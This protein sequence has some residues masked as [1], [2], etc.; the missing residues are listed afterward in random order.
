MASQYEKSNFILAK[1]NTAKTSLPTLGSSNSVPDQE[2]TDLVSDDFS[3][4]FL[5][6]HPG[7]VEFGIEDINAK[8]ICIAGHNLA[9]NGDV[10]VEVHDSS[11][12]YVQKTVTDGKPIF[13]D[14]TLAPT[15]FILLRITG[16][17][18]PATV[19]LSQLMYGDVFNPRQVMQ[20][21]YKSPYLNSHLYQAAVSSTQIMPSRS[22]TKRKPIPV[23]MSFMNVIGFNVNDWID[24]TKFAKRNNFVVVEKHYR[25]DFG[26]D[27]DKTAH[28]GFQAQV[29]H[30]HSG[31]SRTLNDIKLKY[32]AYNGS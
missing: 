26:V 27:L 3:E 8:Y 12:V 23:S 4:K 31:K 13:I 5:I 2:I 25:F 21:S 30:T 22:L 11:G 9:V 15:G 20:G 14:L 29:D 18:L 6:G 32:M 10:T 7:A 24:F 17:N 19:E 16:V 28:I 1:T